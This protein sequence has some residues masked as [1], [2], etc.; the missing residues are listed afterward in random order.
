MQDPR[1]TAERL[2]GAIEW[3]TEVSGFCRCPGGK[4]PFI[5]PVAM[6]VL[7][8]GFRVSALAGAGRGVA[9]TEAR[10]R[11]ANTAGARY[12]SAECG[13]ASL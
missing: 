10:Q 4:P 9:P 3:Q 12:S 5:D 13:L 1:Q 6:R 8:H 11:A 2:L 7:V